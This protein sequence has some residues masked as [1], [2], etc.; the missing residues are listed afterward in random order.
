MLTIDILFYSGLIIFSIGLSYILKYNKLKIKN[1]QL[2]PI[3]LNIAYISS[4]IGTGL[5]TYSITNLI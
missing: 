3:K 5:M 1:K 2:E 4:F